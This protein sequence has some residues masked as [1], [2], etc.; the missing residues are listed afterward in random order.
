MLWQTIR[1]DIL[2]GPALFPF[3]ESHF[4]FPASSKGE[5]RACFK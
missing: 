4:F 1:Q 5:M 3:P 2:P